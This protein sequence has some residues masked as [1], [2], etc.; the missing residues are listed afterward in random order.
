MVPE[1]EVVSAWTFEDMCLWVYCL[2]DELWT[3][4]GPR[5]RRPGPSPVC[6][7]PGLVTMALVG[8]AKGWDQETE[9]L[10]A[11]PR[12]RDLFPHQPSRPRFNRRRRALQGAINEVRRLVLTL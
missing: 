8:D 10:S 2:V 9:L 12:P 11:W 1:T 5:C 4:I 3:Q 6:S 7:D